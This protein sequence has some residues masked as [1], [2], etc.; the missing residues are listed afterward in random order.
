[1]AVLSIVLFAGLVGVGSAAHAS[2]PGTNGPIVFTS[3]SDGDYELYSV[4]PNGSGLHQLTTNTSDD[5]NPSVSPDGTKIAFASTRN[6]NYE[7]YTMGIAGSSPQRLTNNSLVDLDPAWSPDGTKIDFTRSVGSNFDIFVM[8]ANGSSVSDLTNSASTNTAPAWSPDGTKIAFTSDR[9]GNFDVYTMPAAGGVPTQLTNTPAT[10]DQPDWAPD[11]SSILFE[12]DRFSGDFDIFKMQ[13]NGSGVVQVTSGA[14]DETYGVFSPDGT[15]VL[16]ARDAG[17]AKQLVIQNADGS[18]VQQITDNQAINVDGNW[19]PTLEQVPSPT[20]PS[21]TPT[22]ITP[23]P[24]GSTPTQVSPS[25]SQS[26]PGIGC[27][28]SYHGWFEPTQAVFQDDPPEDPNFQDKATKQLSEVSDHQ[29][30]AELVMIDHRKT[31]LYGVLR[32]VMQNRKKHFINSRDAIVIA[33][34]TTCKLQGSQGIHFNITQ[35]QGTLDT[36]VAPAKDSKVPVPSKPGDR[37][38]F[39][40]TINVRPTV[41]VPVNPFEFTAPGPYT[42]QGEALDADGQPTGLIVT[43]QGKVVDTTMPR[44]DFLPA[45]VT[46]QSA[47]AADVAKLQRESDR[48]ADESQAMVPDYYPIATGTQFVHKRR[49]VI[50]ATKTGEGDLRATAAS[51]EAKYQ[52]IA[53]QIYDK[54]G[55]KQEAKKKELRSQEAIAEVTRQLGA[56]G[57]LA[58]I[59]RVIVVLNDHDFDTIV[60][61]P[62]KNTEGEGPTIKAMTASQKVIFLRTGLNHWTVGHELAHTL[63]YLWTGA[64]YNDKGEQTSNVMVHDCGK[65]FHNFEDSK[66][67]WANGVR[68][69]IGGVSVARTPDDI[70]EKKGNLAVNHF[71][72]MSRASAKP[73]WIDQCTYWHLA[74]VLQQ[75]QDPPMLLVQGAIMRN[76]SRTAGKLFPAYQLDGT[77]DLV[78]GMGGKW[79]IVERDATG[80]VLGRFPFRPVWS[81]SDGGRNLLVRSISYRVPEL[82]GAQSI[83]LVG[84]S[85]TLD[86]L[87]YSAN[88][89][90]VTIDY[91]QEG[92]SVPAYGGTVHVS[93]T[94]TDKDGDRLLYSVL[95]STDGG[96]TWTPSSFEQS[97]MFSDVPAGAGDLSVK[98]I[99]TDGVRTTS[100][101]VDFGT[102][103]PGP[104]P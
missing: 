48:L 1:R 42:I 54:T 32:T 66:H 91:P 95:Y 45:I 93:W 72:I 98:V 99:A 62:S 86:S 18:G 2:F 35:G 87:T 14:S 31:V 7:I 77:P 46:D 94:G 85:A 71:S 36:I 50:N 13:P 51:A 68:V 83:D 33:G 58:G 89:P 12:S 56:G 84:P 70:G 22:P 5:L 60:P 52:Q 15:K 44:T 9:T 3:N 43:V 37:K 19:G 82:P 41:G 24:S 74:D 23:S 8:N 64:V 49:L 21:T 97:E 17:A 11:G 69:T 78:Q 101:R 90:Q 92:S 100:S 20:P 103:S 102:T 16:Y 96:S 28:T 67:K 10:D 26:T 81:P 57:Y 27:T 88:A 75:N 40:V 38:P 53:D 25:P 29:Y 4:N 65:D 61:P 34:T 73:R 80:A 76:G 30:N 39:S 55:Q 63:P 59:G 79:A 104:T 6:G 47:G